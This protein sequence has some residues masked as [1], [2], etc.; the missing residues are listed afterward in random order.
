MIGCGKMVLIRMARLTQP[1]IL[2]FLLNPSGV[3]GTQ[4]SSVLEFFDN[5]WVYPLAQA[6]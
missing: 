3:D 2:L 5:T 1:P 4:R 6:S